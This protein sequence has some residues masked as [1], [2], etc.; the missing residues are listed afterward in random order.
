[1]KKCKFLG[2]GGWCSRAP[3]K[4]KCI[5]VELAGDY[6]TEDSCIDISSACRYYEA[7]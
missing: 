4:I 5:V 6:L 3:I 1:M 7:K 2:R